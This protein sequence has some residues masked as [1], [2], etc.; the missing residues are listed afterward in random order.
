MTFSVLRCFIFGLI[1]LVLN[2]CP[3]PGLYPPKTP[4]TTLETKLFAQGLEQY[5]TAGDLTTL[6]LLPKEYP[7][8]AWRTKAE[9]VI[10]LADK[11]QKL[12]IQLD[13]AEQKLLLCKDE[14]DLALCRKEK[15]ALAQDNQLLE[16]TLKRLKE[17]L[18][19]TELHA[20]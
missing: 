13:Q 1:G 20:K 5:L 3:L 11:Q 4:E 16:S 18:I 8:G 2:G 19:E 10:D 12:Q 9:G 14:R 15:E 7:Q 17:V 6:K